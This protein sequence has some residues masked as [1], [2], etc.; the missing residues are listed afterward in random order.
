MIYCALTRC[1][2]AAYVTNLVKHRAALACALKQRP[3]NFFERNPNLSLAN[4]SR[5]KQQMAY[6]KISVWVNFGSKLLSSFSVSAIYSFRKYLRHRQTQTSNGNVE[7]IQLR[8]GS[9]QPVPFLGNRC[10]Q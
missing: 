7:N 10:A 6:E 5:P 9:P 4:A 3:S 1:P 8:F 2:S